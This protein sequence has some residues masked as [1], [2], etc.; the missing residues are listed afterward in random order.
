[1]SAAA[2]TADRSDDETRNA[3]GVSLT[4]DHVSHDYDGLASVRD[5]SLTVKAGEVLCLLGHSGCGKTTLLRIAA[6]IERQ[7]AGRILVDDRE[8]AASGVFLPP[9]KRGI[10]LMFQDYA[11]FPHLTIL[12]NVVF[13]L[14]GTP[15]AEALR[16]G[17]HALARVGL[18]TYAD[19]YPHAL[20]GGEQQRVALARAVAPRPGVLLMDEPFSGLD[21]R[22]RESV[23]DETLSVLAATGATCIV[24][25]HDPEEAM[26][27]GDRIAL[28]RGGEIVQ[29]G[30][31][32]ELYY[33]PR[34]LFVARFFSDLDEI[35]AIVR[36]GYVKTPV[37]TFATENLADGTRVQVCVRPQDVVLRGDAEGVAGTVT[38]K[39]F[40][41]EVDLF[42][43]SIAGLD[44]PLNARLRG[45]IFEV[46]DT[47]SVDVS[48]QGVYIFPL[49]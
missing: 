8:V 30:S 1:M 20:S 34:D 29:V 47:V 6:G 40:L 33:Q 38:K 21:R 44:R 41:G 16:D 12:D 39:R 18:E 4:F 14:A 46:G 19:D 43:V 23:R 24:V 48:R 3:G 49:E 27:M 7:K 31:A 35:T 36:N 13:G 15:R 10:G 26:R 42:E 9:E 22:L 11:L 17:R 2:K 32:E 45:A 5:V 37:G 25:T 28:M